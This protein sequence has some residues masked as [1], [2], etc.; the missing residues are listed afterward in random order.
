MGGGASIGVLAIRSALTLS[1]IT[2]VT[3]GGG[4]GGAG[5]TGGN[6]GMGGMGGVGG[7]ASP[8][9]IGTGGR[10]GDGRRGGSGGAGGGGGGGPSIGVWVEGMG[11][12]MIDAVNFRLGMPGV[13]GTSAAAGPSEGRRGESANVYPM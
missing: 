10:G 1:G 12:P 8:A 2:I 5:G 6:G 9:E 3:G 11:R 7:N 13:G 4:A